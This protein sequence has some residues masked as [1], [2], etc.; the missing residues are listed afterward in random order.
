MFCDEKGVQPGSDYYFF[1]P[2]NIGQSMLFYL[3]SCGNFTV[4]FEY[5]VQRENYSSYLCIY[6]KA[7]KLSITSQGET[8]IAEKGAMAF[9]N[10]HKAHEYHA[11]GPTEFIWAHFDGSNIESFY[12]EFIKENNGFLRKT[13]NLRIFN[14]LEQIL[15]SCRTNQVLSEVQYAKKLYLLL[16]DLIGEEQIETKSIKE[17][18]IDDAFTYIKQH[19]SEDLTLKDIAAEVNMSVYHFSRVFKARVGYSP[20][21]FLIKTRLDAARYLLK[22]TNKSIKNIAYAVGYNNV[23]GFINAFK[24]KVGIS[25][26]KFRKYPI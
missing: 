24:T 10:C 2:S 15:V 1:T 26:G 13:N 9:I 12:Q 7:G 23:S 18:T 6:V 14:I 25:P 21:E 17:G 8:M 22:T 5:R 4:D 19:Y 11:V 3:G 16:L 20:Y